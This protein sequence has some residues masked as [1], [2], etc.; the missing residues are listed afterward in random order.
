ME[1]EG[2]FSV[3]NGKAGRPVLRVSLAMTDADIVGRIVSILEIKNRVSTHQRPL[4]NRK[5]ELTAYAHGADA[6]RIMRLLKPH[7]GE[8]RR[9]KINE[10]LSAPYGTYSH[11]P[12]VEA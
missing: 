7:L 1:G 12:R 11:Q 4:E 9:A 6:E 5:L 2:C 8:R 3:L 10:I